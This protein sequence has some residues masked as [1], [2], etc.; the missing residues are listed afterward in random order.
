MIDSRRQLVQAEAVL[1]FVVREY[2]HER[3]P[4]LGEVRSDFTEAVYWHPVLV[5]PDTGKAAV[6]FQL[7]DDI[8][9]YQVLVAGHTLDGRLGAI[10]KTIEARKPFSVDPKLP[11][12][13]AHTDTVNVPLRVTND[14]DVRR[15]VALAT[16]ATGFKTTDP[17][18]DVIDL[19]PNGKGRKLLK[20][21][22]DKL[23]GDAS[24]LI[25]GTSIPVAEKDTVRRTIRVAPDGF[26]GVGSFSDM[27][28][29]GRAR[30]GLTLPKDV[31][32]GTLKVRLEMYPT[33]MADLVKGLD[34]LLREPY[35]CFEQ[36]STT[37]YPNALILDYMNQTNQTN[38]AAAARAKALLDKGYGRLTSFECPDTPLS[39][40]HG[41]EWFGKADSQHEALTAYGLLQ[42]KD[43]ARVHPV[44]PELI[45]RTQAFLM[46][47]RD[48]QGG[49]K[50]N[51]RAL[52]GFGGAPKYVT[53]AY[54]VWA[55]VESD[56]DGTER[57]DLK[58]ELAAL[59]AAALDESSVSG[60]D[61][62]SVALVAN[63]MLLRGDRET[64]HKLLDRL[65]DKHT[66]N[67][68]VTG[69]VTS[70]T[71]SGGRDLQIEATALALLGWLRANDPSY[72]TV[73]KEATKWIAQQ[74][75]GYGGFGSTQSTI[76]A[77]KALSLYAKKAAHP[78][79][80]GEL[81]LLVDG[82]VV[83]ARPFTEKDVEVIGLDVPNAEAVFKPGARSEVDVV[84]DAKQPYPFALSYT[85]TTLTPLSADNCA[86]RISTKLARGA[87]TEGDTVPLAVTLENRQ[88]QGQG[89]TTAIIGLPAGMKVPADLKQLTD[90]REKGAIAY[91]EL[92]GP[93]ELVLY[94]R[95]L[96][97]EQ[98][99]ALSID[100]VCD[101]PGTYRGP[102]SR[103]YL[104]YNADH[105]HW[106][107]PLSIT[108]AP[109]AGN[110]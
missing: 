94:W 40:K 71:R 73:V 23:E 84:T 107:E 62:Y 51:A 32:P 64:A 27:L 24:L 1:P 92:K 11:L 60:K 103:G 16:T 52:D 53:D 5:L 54:I 10:T 41:F 38:P 65:K 36:T 82:K 31:V 99:V 15:N 78:P 25:E 12:E 97:P 37:N 45:R 33:S 101:V 59:K 50:R 108:I 47:R 69:A 63:V 55:L 70:I 88:K 57:L 22:A 49:F 43:M 29:N 74:R 2:A 7:S 102:A 61:A 46:S 18:R 68:A 28:E 30:N 95:E 9:R 93:R 8:A 58:A 56:P 90:L 20:L 13:I 17:L 110:Q 87:A 81:R 79:E 100:L 42:F 75:G 39:T 72:A 104:Y 89:M 105:K 80:S 109:M 19:Q 14:S 98:K 26:P 96:A 76:M 91:F 44:D 3:D 85:Y 83:A 35:G 106:V 77:L 4:A 21:N 34:G 66:K 86:V 6:E 67:G 48:G